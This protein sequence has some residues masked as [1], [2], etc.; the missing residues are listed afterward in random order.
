METIRVE[1]AVSLAPNPAWNELRIRMHRVWVDFAHAGIDPQF[2]RAVRNLYFRDIR[3]QMEV[4]NHFEGEL[5]SLSFT[6]TWTLLRKMSEK[7]LVKFTEYH[8]QVLNDGHSELLQ[9]IY[10]RVYAIRAFRKQVIRAFVLRQTPSKMVGYTEAIGEVASY[11]LM[12][13]LG[14]EGLKPSPPIE[15]G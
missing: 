5:K 6:A 3:N 12:R 14:Q 7:R 10:T 11:R 2:R 13:L 1:S 8:A 9:E 15:R 4:I